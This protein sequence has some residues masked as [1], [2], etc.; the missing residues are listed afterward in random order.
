MTG[1]VLVALL[2]HQVY[3]EDSLAVK[4]VKEMYNLGARYDK[5]M[6][7]IELFADEGLT[8]AFNLQ[9]S[10]EDLCGNEYDVMWQSQDPEYKRKLTFSTVATNQIKVNLGAGQ[11]HKPQSVNY[12]LTCKSGVCKVSD[13]VDS[14]GSLKN[15]INKECKP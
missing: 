2:S 8:Q 12:K 3:A 4:T 1:L 10:S 11:W 15:R 9:Q 13:V 14:E 5:G 6:E 7:V